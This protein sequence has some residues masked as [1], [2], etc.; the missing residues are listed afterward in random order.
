MCQAFLP[1][2]RNGGRLVNV[3]SQSGQLKYFAPHL[4][5]RF[6]KPDL[7]IPEVLSIAN[8]YQV[9]LIAPLTIGQSN[10]I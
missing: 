6:L 7:T 8:E 9:R 2:M 3:S 10:L 1:L 4:R 5:E